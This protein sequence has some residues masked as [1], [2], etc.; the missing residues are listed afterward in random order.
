[1]KKENDVIHAECQTEGVLNDWIVDN[2][3]IG[4]H[5]ILKEHFD[6]FNLIKGL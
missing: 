4:Y 3:K 5:L 1:M 2:A 6:D